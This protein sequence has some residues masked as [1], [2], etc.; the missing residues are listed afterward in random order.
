MDALLASVP[1][2]AKVAV[3]TL[4]GSLCPMTLGH[5]QCFVEARRLLLA[6]PQEPGRP[7]RLEVFQECLGFV[8]LNDDAFVM[9]KLKATGKRPLSFDDRAW[10]A[11]LTVQGLDWLQVDFDAESLRRLKADWPSLEFIEFMLNGADDAVKMQTWLYAGPRNRAITIGRPGYTCAVVDGMREQGI[12][13]AS[14]HFVLGP[15]L[16][17]ISSSAVRAAS[18]RGDRRTL[19]SM[20]QPSVADWM[21]RHAGHDGLVSL[22]FLFL[23]TTD[24]GAL[25]HN[26]LPPKLTA[27]NAFAKNEVA[28]LHNVLQPEESRHL[29]DMVLQAA[30][31]PADVSGE[32]GPSRQAFVASMRTQLYMKDLA[33][34]L[35]SRLRLC[36]ELLEPLQID[37]ARERFPGCRGR[38][39][40]CGVNPLFR[41]IKY[42]HGGV[43]LPH[44]DNQHILGEFCRSLKTVVVYL[45]EDYC[46]GETEFVDSSHQ[47]GGGAGIV[48]GDDAMAYKYA[49]WTRMATYPEIVSSVTGVRGSAIVFDH[50][51]L[52]Q[53]TELRRGEKIVLRTDLFYKRVPCDAAPQEGPMS[54]HRLLTTLKKAYRVKISAEL[55]AASFDCRRFNIAVLG[56]NNT[57]KSTACNLLFRGASTNAGMKEFLQS[58]SDTLGA[59]RAATA[60]G[61]K[62]GS[63]LDNLNNFQQ[64]F[65][66]EGRAT[67]WDMMRGHDLD[68][69]FPNATVWDLPGLEVQDGSADAYARRACLE[70]FDAAILVVEKQLSEDDL[71]LMTYLKQAWSRGAP[72]AVPTFVLRSKVD[73]S[74][75]ES[76]RQFVEDGGCERQWLFDWE[77]FSTKLYRDMLETVSAANRARAPSSHISGDLSKDDLPLE[78]FFAMGLVEDVDKERHIGSRIPLKEV[79]KLAR[80]FFQQSHQLRHQLKVLAEQ[81]QRDTGFPGRLP[82][83]VEDLE[84]AFLGMVRPWDEREE[85]VALDIRC[86]D[87]KELGFGLKFQRGRRV[88]VK[89][90]GG[91]QD[92]RK[93]HGM[94]EGDI[95]TE[96]PI[97]R[98]VGRLKDVGELGERIEMQAGTC[99]SIVVARLLED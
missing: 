11:S 52:H 49:G 48:C 35:W 15:E 8:C 51:L 67:T 32:Q 70:A 5:L 26:T 42:D 9:H 29:S 36:E 64:F 23:N 7:L 94:Q 31:I 4:W 89:P 53:S 82:A 44:Y 98:P 79:R 18:E 77:K 60:D 90:A 99:V 85:Y 12:D 2:G 68:I 46:G 76:F 37:E 28:L 34:F 47:G 74:I 62:I 14:G 21:L 80:R 40:A 92:L 10:L 73:R 66:R 86:P 71:C 39:Q 56:S 75:V 61:Q 78:R 59:A 91:K 25:R 17:D 84:A 96:F 63:I 19:L 93:I 43:L 20:L 1:D 13:G 72:A 27:V 45:T 3:V 38:W 50:R 69:W 24:S 55:A 83:A 87:R 54:D 97:G 16:E 95:L 22:D 6:S 57:G 33:T 41:F 65:V 30:L 58:V 88:I 81:K